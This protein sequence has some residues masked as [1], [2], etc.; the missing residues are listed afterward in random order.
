MPEVEISSA[1]LSVS[2]SQCIQIF[3]HYKPQFP[4]ASHVVRILEMLEDRLG[5]P[6]TQD[7]VLSGQNINHVG[8]TSLSPRDVAFEN[9]AA[10]SGHPET[11]MSMVDLNNIDFDMTWAMLDDLLQAEHPTQSLNIPG[12]A[13]VSRGSVFGLDWEGLR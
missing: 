8:A 11:T 6:E 7:H 3:E 4:S 9:T 2:W 1:S 10:Q 13:N 5:H 12:D